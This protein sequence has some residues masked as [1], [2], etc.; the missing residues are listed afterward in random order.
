MKSTGL[1]AVTLWVTL[2]S[3]SPGCSTM[4]PVYN[5][6]VVPPGES[7]FPGKHE[8]VVE[9]IASP[10]GELK[11]LN[12]PRQG[13]GRQRGAAKARIFRLLGS[14]PDATSKPEPATLRISVALSK[15]VET[16]IVEGA[17]GRI[18]RAVPH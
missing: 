7:R 11:P 13:S 3:L 6:Q 5:V 1:L 8:I 15:S 12:R 4:L 16:V 10:D 2:V 17:N 9:T 14:Q 18:V